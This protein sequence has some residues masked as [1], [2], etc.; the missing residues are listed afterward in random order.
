MP[1]VELITCDHFFNFFFS[2]IN[3]IYLCLITHLK[4]A[5][6]LAI[7]IK[8]GF[9][10]QAKTE[11]VFLNNNN[12][13]VLSF[14]FKD[15]V[16]EAGMSKEDTSREERFLHQEVDGSDIDTLFEPKAL[17]NFE[18]IGSDQKLEDVTFFDESGELQ[19]NL[20]IKGNNLLA[21]HSLVCPFSR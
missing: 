4:K 18:T 11:L 12:D 10:L 2:V 19:Q 3:R 14:P 21:L 15:T 6:T 9:I 8:L 5:D 13:V 1:V 16:L 17:T 20:L 7:A